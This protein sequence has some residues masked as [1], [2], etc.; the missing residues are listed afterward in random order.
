MTRGA[1]LV[2]ALAALAAAGGAGAQGPGAAPAAGAP[3][4][5]PLSPGAATVTDATQLLQALESG[6]GDITLA[7]ERSLAAA[8]G[9]ARGP[10]ATRPAVHTHTLGTHPFP[11]LATP[12]C[13]ATSP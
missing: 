2:V 5:G 13:Q 11:P 7:G 9:T 3:L 1:L 6:A 4:W 12:S 8:A 10:A